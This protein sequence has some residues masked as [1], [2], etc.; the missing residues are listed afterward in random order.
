MQVWSVGLGEVQVWSVGLGEA[1]VWSARLEHS[2][3]V[4]LCRLVVH[5]PVCTESSRRHGAQEGTQD[6]HP[7]AQTYCITASSSTS[8]PPC[9]LVAFFIRKTVRSVQC[10]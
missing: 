8:L 10:I 2:V 9:S 1:Q 6:E 7:N 5:R 4:Q 3:R